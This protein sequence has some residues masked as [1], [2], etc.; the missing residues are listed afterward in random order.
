M[1]A[2]CVKHAVFGV[3]SEKSE[4]SVYTDMSVASVTN[5][6][7]A[8]GITLENQNWEWASGKIENLT[9]RREPNKILRKKLL[10]EFQPSCC[11]TI[12]FH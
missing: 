11:A 2:K 8:L 12:P 5:M 6:R 1:S 10:M 7:Y 9:N 4:E 3:Q